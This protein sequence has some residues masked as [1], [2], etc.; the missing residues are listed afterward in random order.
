MEE[1]NYTMPNGDSLE[2]MSVDYL[3]EKD[4]IKLQYY[5]TTGQSGFIVIELKK[6]Q[7]IDGT[8]I[9]VYSKF[10]GTPSAFEQHSLVTFDYKNGTLLANKNLGLPE[11]LETAAFL[12]DNL[13]D[14]LNEEKIS[15]STS[16]NLNP[17]KSNQVEYEISPQSDQFDP[18]IETKI[19][20]FE[21]NGQRFQK[22]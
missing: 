2:T 15:V 1:G 4:Y 13:P 6:F 19:L 16:Y 5:F 14:G 7:K 18:C 9:V 21:W 11:T 10:G 22:M 20:T 8:P 17:G 12:K 3:T